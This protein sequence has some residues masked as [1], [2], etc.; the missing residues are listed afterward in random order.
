MIIGYRRFSI[1]MY[2]SPR[3]LRQE[4]T[5]DWLKS[6]GV[7]KKNTPFRV[8]NLHHVRVRFRFSGLD[9]LIPNFVWD[10][11]CV[12]N[13]L[14]HSHQT[15]VNASVCRYLTTFSLYP[16]IWG[17]LSNPKHIFAANSNMSVG[18]GFGWS[19][20]L[21]SHSWSHVSLDLVEANIYR[22]SSWFLAWNT[23]GSCRWY[24]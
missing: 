17:R 3:Q 14:T 20:H 10:P 21:H 15:A 16:S 24:P 22:F 8:G 7:R 13:E 1:P 6:L 12:P 23:G 5:F 4:Q 18:F 2:G 11:R 19:E 9:G